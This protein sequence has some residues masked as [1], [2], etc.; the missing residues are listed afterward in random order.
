MTKAAL[1]RAPGFPVLG[2]PSIARFT[3]YLTSG[4]GKGCC[5]T[6]H[7]H[8]ATSI[9]CRS[10]DA[11]LIQISNRKQ[12]LNLHPLT[13][14]QPRARPLTR[15]WRQKSFRVATGRAGQ[16]SQNPPQQRGREQPDGILPCRITATA[17]GLGDPPATHHH[18]CPRALTQTPAALGVSS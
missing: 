4:P 5:R 18:L 16:P 8:T 9:P 2:G 13:I 15:H 1:Q 17:R 12:P 7:G 11:P 10:T 6:S 3:N 14:V